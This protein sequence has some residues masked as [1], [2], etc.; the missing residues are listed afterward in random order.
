MWRVNIY[1]DVYGE[2]YTDEK[3]FEKETDAYIFFEDEIKI[4]FEDEIMDGL[5]SDQR[6]QDIIGEGVYA[7]ED[8]ETEIVITLEEILD[9]ENYSL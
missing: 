8:E 4:E 7:F 6:I 9:E 2:V 5:I 1:K 3:V